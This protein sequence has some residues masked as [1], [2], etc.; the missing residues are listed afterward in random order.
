LIACS[1]S[2]NDMMT[3]QD[4]D[5]ETSDDEADDGDAGEDEEE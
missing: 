1:G 3:I 2:L 4:A 5:E